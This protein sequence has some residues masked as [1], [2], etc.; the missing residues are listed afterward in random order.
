MALVDDLAD[1][2]RTEQVAAVVGALHRIRPRAVEEA[3]RALGRFATRRAPAAI[4]RTERAA[5]TGNLPR[6]LEDVAAV[7]ID[8][9][10]PT[11][12]RERWQQGVDAHPGLGQRIAAGRIVGGAWFAAIATEGDPVARARAYQSAVARGRRDLDRVAPD[13]AS[14]AARLTADLLGGPVRTRPGHAGPGFVEF[15]GPGALDQDGDVHIDW[16]GLAAEHPLG[17]F[18]EAYSFV[19]MVR[20]PEEGGD[21]RVWGIG[22]AADGGAVDEAGPGTLVGYRP[23]TLVAFPAQDLHQITAMRGD[24]SRITVTWHARRAGPDPGDGWEIW[25]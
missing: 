24:R 11:E 5:A 14:R 9:A 17:L 13:L 19:L 3:R 1:R 20:P 7:A 10:V 2:H 25:L 16:E 23:G 4:H 18:A 21:L 15:G 6:L 12:V 22:A 8:D